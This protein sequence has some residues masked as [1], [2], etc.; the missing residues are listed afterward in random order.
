MNTLSN[1]KLH[2]VATLFATG[3]GVGF[4]PKA[5]GTWGSLLGLGAAYLGHYAAAMA[6]GSFWQADLSLAGSGIGILILG[7][8]SCWGLGSILLTERYWQCHD[9]KRI[10]IDEVI[11]QM[12]ASIWFHP[13]LL[14]YGITFALFR[15]FDIYKPGPIGW[16][17]RR[18]FAA[19][20]TLADDLAAGVAAALVWYLLKPLI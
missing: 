10:V 18:V 13:D 17:D 14:T 8:A 19:W 2:K 16:I 3:F 7:L 5:P 4:L 12:V 1:S 9:D 15:F 11:G 6:S 20:G